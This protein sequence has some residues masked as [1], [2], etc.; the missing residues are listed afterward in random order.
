MDV[1]VD[2]Q[3]RNYD[4]GLSRYSSIPFYYNTKDGKYIYG[5]TKQLGQNVD[6]VIHQVK[7]NDTL[8]SIALFYYGRPDYFWI[9]ADFNRI[10]DPFIDLKSKFDTL[11]VPS[12]SYIY[13]ED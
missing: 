3:T 7:A 5:L 10:V 9:V 12:I 6:Y 13:Y 8:D 4:N 2:K 11:K 1:L